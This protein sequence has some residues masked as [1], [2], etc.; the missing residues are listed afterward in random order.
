MIKS[1]LGWRAC[2]AWTSCVVLVLL[3]L[4]GAQMV[5]SKRRENRCMKHYFVHTIEHPTKNCEKKVRNKT[6]PCSM[7]YS[8]LDE[9]VFLFVLGGFL[10]FFGGGGFIF[11][12]KMCGKGVRRFLF[13]RKD[14]LSVKPLHFSFWLW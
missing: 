12:R 2:C 6:M 9:N 14:V 13:F 5:D 10:S 7:W 1:P 3:L 8:H 11:L 4:C